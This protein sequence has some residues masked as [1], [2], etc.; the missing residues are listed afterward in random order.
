MDVAALPI[1]LDPAVQE[2]GLGP[3]LTDLMQQ[4][5]AQH[6]DRRADF[7]RLRGSVAIKATDAEVALTMDFRPEGL[8][9]RDG[10][11]GRPDLRISTASLSLLE[12]TDARLRLG[13]PDPCHPSGRKVLRKLVSGDLRLWGRGLVLKP[14][15]LTRLTRLLNVALE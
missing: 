5:V 13:L 1:T 3:M 2:A 6:P 8:S 11:Q 7:D 14:L 15:L 10:I 4:N 9:V 12:L